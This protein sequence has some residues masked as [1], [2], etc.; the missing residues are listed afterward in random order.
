MESESFATIKKCKDA[1]ERAFMDETFA[2]TNEKSPEL[3]SKVKYQPDWILYESTMGFTALFPSFPE[4]NEK[5]INENIRYFEALYKNQDFAFMIRLFH[6]N[7][8]N[9]D[10]SLAELFNKFNTP[11]PGMKILEENDM[12]IAGNTGKYKKIE[13][14]NGQQT[15]YSRVIQ[16]TYKMHV[17]S[18]AV[19]GNKS[20]VDDETF[21][22]F[23]GGINLTK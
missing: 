10:K 17:I 4:E 14:M 19:I 1:E 22:K 23:I 16:F 8:A 9:N 21:N 20:F 3:L 12:E 6:D 18:V 5:D 11:E 13:A 7:T 2:S 15:V